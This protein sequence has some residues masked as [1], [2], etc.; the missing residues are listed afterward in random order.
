MFRPVLN[1]G[2]FPKQGTVSHERAEQSSILGEVLILKVMR[3]RSRHGTFQ[4]GRGSAGAYQP[5]S[6]LTGVESEHA[7]MSLVPPS[8]VGCFA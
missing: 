2:S 5:S 7:L 4:V 1:T 8:N 6:L 3:P